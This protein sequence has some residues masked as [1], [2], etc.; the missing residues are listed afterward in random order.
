MMPEIGYQ[1][2]H[3]DSLTKWRLFLKNWNLDQS[4]LEFDQAAAFLETTNQSFALSHSEQR[5]LFYH[6]H[7]LHCEYLIFFE[8]CLMFAAFQM[9][10]T[11]HLKR[12]QDLKHFSTEEFYHTK[13]FR[14]YLMSERYF[15]YPKNQFQS[16][17]GSLFRK[18]YAQVLKLEPWAILLPGAKSE[19]YFLQ[20]FKHNLSRRSSFFQKLNQLHSADEVHHIP[21]D[22]AL[23]NSMLSQ[24]KPG[25]QFS[26]WLGTTVLIILNQFLVIG[27]FYK[28]VDV[29][30]PERSWAFKIR[31]FLILSRLQLRGPV[32]EQTRKALRTL[33]SRETRPIFWFLRYGTW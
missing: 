11:Q 18:V 27:S 31:Y 5:T 23:I 21:F 19:I 24:R 9:R 28:M 3:K 6:F 33:Y 2:K 32:Y 22:F 25:G 16:A 13:A 20:Y 15:S 30:L 4:P 7:Q 1:E 8:Q 12:D 17:H 29:S 14:K 10:G 26:F